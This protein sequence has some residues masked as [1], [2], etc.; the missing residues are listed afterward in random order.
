[1]KKQILRSALVAV[2]ALT[3]VA[4]DSNGPGN[5]LSEHAGNETLARQPLVPICHVSGERGGVVLRLLAP[6]AYEAHLGAGHCNADGVCDHAPISTASWGGVDSDR[7][8]IDDGCETC[9]IDDWDDELAAVQ[10]CTGVTSTRCT[11]GPTPAALY[12]DAASSPGWFVGFACDVSD[13]TD[14]VEYK[15]LRL[16]G[17]TCGE[18]GSAFPAF[19]YSYAEMR[20]CVLELDAALG[21]DSCAG[22]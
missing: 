7:N 13:G 22:Q 5:A 10:S 1:M 3:P 12:Y 9:P 18:R 16:G 19:A 17:A 6:P 8:G 4:C 20:A 11:L 15:Y 2:L 14:C 21:T